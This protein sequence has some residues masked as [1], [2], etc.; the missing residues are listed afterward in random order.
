MTQLPCDASD[1]LRLI[2][3]RLHLVAAAL[4][5]LGLFAACSTT[6]TPPAALPG[7][8]READ[9]QPRTDHDE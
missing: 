1:T 3:L 2:A 5:V 4:L 7:I 8:D 6:P 9:P